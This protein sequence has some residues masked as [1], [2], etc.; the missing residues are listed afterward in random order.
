MAS[1]DPD[2]RSAEDASTELQRALAHLRRLVAVREGRV[3]ASVQAE[4]ARESERVAAER[5]RFWVKR[6]RGL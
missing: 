4:A 5:V 1:S 3:P 6:H 2:L